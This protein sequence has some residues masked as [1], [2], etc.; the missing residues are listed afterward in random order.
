MYA[1]MHVCMYAHM[2]MRREEG[3]AEKIYR[4]VLNTD[5]GAVE[6]KGW[7]GGDGGGWGG[8]AQGHLKRLAYV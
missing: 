1:C 5:P 6:G 2:Y 7:G 3:A 8:K 4:H